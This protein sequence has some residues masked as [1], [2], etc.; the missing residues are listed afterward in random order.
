MYSNAP[1]WFIGLLV[2]L[3][4]GFWP[5]YFSPSASGATFGHHFHAIAMI[6]WVLMLI[7]QPWLIRTRK[8]DTHRL[9]GRFSF[10]WAPLVVISA[11]YI[12]LENLQK[13]PQPFPPVG[14]SFF[15]LGLASAPFFA[16]LYSL[17]IINRKDMQLHAR[18]MAATTLGFITP[19]LGRL[20][21]RVGE[22]TGFGFLNFQTALW[23]PA[24]VGGVMI[25]H[26]AR[27]GGPVRLPWILATA[28]WVGIVLGF[29]FLP[30]FA[31]FSN[32]ADWY[33]GFA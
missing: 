8:R 10:V 6:G 2:M 26:D 30:G 15:W 7:V 19:G 3:I 14:L 27:K 33:L 32:V 11:L 4:L 16:V 20:L 17:A 13:L 21:G 23:F 24:F 29:Y 1:F 12:V 28:L 9:I 5:S 22:A 31:W 25:V 18:Y